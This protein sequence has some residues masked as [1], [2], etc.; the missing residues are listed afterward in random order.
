MSHWSVGVPEGD[1]N[2]SYIAMDGFSIGNSLNAAIVSSIVSN[3]CAESADEGI[4]ET[5]MGSR[6]R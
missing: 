5:S 1:I 3:W 6:P 4:L 2:G